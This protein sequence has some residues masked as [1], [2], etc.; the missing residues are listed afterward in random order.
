MTGVSPGSQRVAV[1]I[2]L[3][4]GHGF[5]GRKRDYDRFRDLS[6]SL[7]GMLRFREVGGPNGSRGFHCPLDAYLVSDLSCPRLW[8]KIQPRERDASLPGTH[9]MSCSGGRNFFLPV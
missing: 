6:P 2:Y 9:I 8:L 5:C 7:I 4:N 1:G 3:L